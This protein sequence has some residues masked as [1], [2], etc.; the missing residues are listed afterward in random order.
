MGYGYVSDKQEEIGFIDKTKILKYV[1]EEE[2][3][4]LV[5]GYAPKEMEYVTSPFRIDSNPMCYFERRGDNLRFIDFAD[6]ATKMFP[7]CFDAVQ[8]FYNLP[9]FYQSLKFIYQKLIK[10]KELTPIPERKT[11]ERERVIIDIISRKFITDD[12][13]FWQPYQISRQNLIDDLVFPVSRVIV[14]NSK[15]G[16][17]SERVRTI[18]YAICGFPENRKKLYYPYTT[19]RKRFITNCT[20][21]DIG[22]ISSLPPYGRQLIISKS[23]KDWRVLRNQGKNSIWFQNEG[24][25]PDADLLASIVKRFTRIIVLYDNDTQ[26]MSSSVDIS[27]FINSMFPGKARPLWLPESLKPMGIT[28]PSD[29]I[30]AKGKTELNRFL[31]TYHL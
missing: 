5:F 23:Y 27:H 19:G 9:N 30:Q 6:P 24:V 12:A 3:F 1:T 7:D 11:V 13:S 31:E 17:Y 22:G 16:D 25:I 10:N 29:L 4:S 15:H 2:I 20:N 14:T 26:G 28:D 18:C 21:D 8:R